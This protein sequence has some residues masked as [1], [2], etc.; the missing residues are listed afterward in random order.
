MVLGLERARCN[1]R[2]EDSAQCLEPDDLEAGP[3]ELVHPFLDGSHDAVGE[4][5]GAHRSAVV[6]DERPRRDERL[7]CKAA[8]DGQLVIRSRFGPNRGCPLR[9]LLPLE[10]GLALP[11]RA[12]YAE[13]GERELARLTVRDQGPSRS[14][15]LDRQCE[16]VVQA[17]L[18]IEQ[19]RI[20]EIAEPAPVC[21]G[22]DVQRSPAK[23]RLACETGLTARDLTI[24]IDVNRQCRPARIDVAKRQTVRMLDGALGRGTLEGVFQETKERL[25]LGCFE[26]NRVEVTRH[27]ARDPA[28]LTQL[29]P[30]DRP[31]DARRY[32]LR[33]PSPDRASAAMRIEDPEAR[34]EALAAVLA[35][36]EAI[37]EPA[38]RTETLRRLAEA[39]VA[40]I[41]ELAQSEFLRS[42]TSYRQAAERQDDPRQLTDQLVAARAVEHP[43]DRALALAELAQDGIDEGL[44]AI[45]ILGEAFDAHRCWSFNG[46]EVASVAIALARSGRLDDVLAKASLIRDPEDRVGLLAVLLSG[47]RGPFRLRGDSDPVSPLANDLAASRQIADR[48]LAAA[49]EAYENR[50]ED[51][52]WHLLNDLV[53]SLAAGGMADHALEVLEWSLYEG[54]ETHV[55]RALVRASTEV[56]DIAARRLVDTAL[57]ASRDL[58]ESG[59]YWVALEVLEVAPALTDRGLDVRAYVNEAIA[60]TTGHA[61]DDRNTAWR[62]AVTARARA[63]A[64]DDVRSLVREGLTAAH[65]ANLIE[66]VEAFVGAAARGGQED[67]ALEAALTIGDGSDRLWSL[68]QAAKLLHS[69]GGSAEHAITHAESEARNAGDTVGAWLLLVIAELLA[70]T[71][72]DAKPM[73]KQALS[74]ARIEDPSLAWGMVQVA[75][76]FAQLGHDPTSVLDEALVVARAEPHPDDRAGALVWLGEGLA[77]LGRDATGTFSEALAE[78][79]S[80]RDPVSRANLI[81]WIAERQALSGIDPTDAVDEAIALGAGEPLFGRGGAEC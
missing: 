63:A 16:R 44:D 2:V 71:G 49:R 36:V 81:A 41:A 51:L 53:A 23:T 33:V 40:T 31:L 52:S 25:R 65:A 54:D 69:L 22:N 12:V 17:V 27:P 55:L 24:P 32:A 48:V 8:N 26:A 68:V 1:A 38:V 13:S 9:L 60:R 20:D 42:D 66:A 61:V 39:T 77:H 7:G 30:I 10:G 45:E 46:G 35:D 50:D 57:S 3:T 80:V 67:L 18:V 75:E 58:P 73:L 28:T 5:V 78:A 34:L 72:A 76:V 37:D 6:E 43:T 62:L 4:H 64:G 29:E 56:E 14:D 59:R 15:G 11:H 47:D 21:I 79:R 70:A 19:L 74:A